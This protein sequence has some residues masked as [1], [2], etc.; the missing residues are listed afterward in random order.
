M[1]KSSTYKRYKFCEVAIPSIWLNG[2]VNCIYFC[3][4]PFH[5]FPSLSIF[6]IFFFFLVALFSTNNW[7]EITLYRFNSSFWPRNTRNLSYYKEWLEEEGTTGEKR[8]SRKNG[9]EKSE[10]DESKG[11]G[12]KRKSFRFIFIYTILFGVFFPRFFYF[13]LTPFSFRNSH[14]LLEDVNV[15]EFFIYSRII[16]TIRRKDVNLCTIYS[17]KNPNHVANLNDFYFSLLFC[18]IFPPKMFVLYFEFGITKFR[19]NEKDFSY[20]F[21]EEGEAAR[22]SIGELELA[23]YSRQYWN[24]TMLLRCDL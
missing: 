24:K 18:S 9:K 11:C 14:L 6:L 5:F 22:R 19:K 2:T 15:F 1:I 4:Y 3:F 16:V 20:S 10:K 7:P 8:D 13:L 23:S 17:R 12:V 21:S